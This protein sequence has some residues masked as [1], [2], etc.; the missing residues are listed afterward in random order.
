MIGGL[1]HDKAREFLLLSL[2]P[3]L[4]TTYCP[5]QLDAETFQ[6]Q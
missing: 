2:R 6:Q 5:S 3:L 1:I 4:V